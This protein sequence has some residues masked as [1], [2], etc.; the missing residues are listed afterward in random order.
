MPDPVT[1]PIELRPTSV[2]RPAL[3]FVLSSTVYAATLNPASIQAWNRHLAAAEAKVTADA[4][5]PAGFLWLDQSANRRNR[6]HN[7]EIVADE[8]YAPTEKTPDALIHDW[9]GAAFIPDARIEDVIAV[10]RN[11]NHYKN[12]YSPTVIRSNTL[13]QNASLDHWTV[14]MMN[15]TLL[16]RIAVEADCQATFTQVSDK[17]WYAIS[18][19]TQIHQIDNYGRADQHRLPVDQGDGYIWRLASITRFEERDGGVY[20][21]VEALGLTRDI[22]FGLRFILDPV[23]RRISRNSLLE[24]L[25]QTGKAVDE[26]LATTEQ[27]AATNP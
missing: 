15:Q 11:Y 8:T 19:S 14:T 9:T 13:E 12:Y 16:L 23:V 17:R 25:K 2:S 4:Q 21:E 26:F 1:C 18:T 20:L 7:G 5:K 6:V 3:L 22:P 10:V 27:I 24:S